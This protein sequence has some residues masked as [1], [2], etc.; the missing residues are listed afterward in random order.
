MPRQLDSTLRY[1]RRTAVAATLCGGVS[2]SS[3]GSLTISCWQISRRESLTDTLTPCGDAG[4]VVEHSCCLPTT[5]ATA[6]YP[7]NPQHD[8]PRAVNNCCGMSPEK[9][10]LAGMPA[11]TSA[12]TVIPLVR[13]GQNRINNCPC[14]FKYCV[15]GATV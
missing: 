7:V 3:G 2:V 10:R 5:V 15:A 14:K 11:S 9:S 12:A 8:L 6:V 1:T 13:S 4:G